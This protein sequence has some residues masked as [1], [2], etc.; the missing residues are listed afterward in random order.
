[1]DL[2]G[3]LSEQAAVGSDLD[4]ALRAAET[5]VRGEPPAKKLDELIILMS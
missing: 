5:V 1:L 2:S 3:L 4:V